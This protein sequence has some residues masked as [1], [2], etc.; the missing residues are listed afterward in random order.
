MTRNYW[1]IDGATPTPISGPELVR[2]FGR[3]V[4]TP[5]GKRP[6]Y[7]F[8]DAAGC[9]MAR[10]SDGSAKPCLGTRGLTRDQAEERIEAWVIEDDISGR[11]FDHEP[12][13]DPDMGIW[14]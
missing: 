9:I 6:R 7:Y 14:L 13:L 1:H 4:C 10:E 3:E 2:F 8:D 5:E 11:L 12:V